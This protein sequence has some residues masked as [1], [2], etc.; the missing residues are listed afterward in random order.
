MAIEF[1]YK[2][3]LKDVKKKKRAIFGMY[4]HTS[5][6][7]YIYPNS[8]HLSHDQNQWKELSESRQ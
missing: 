2:I 6:G 5:N 4:L 1:I 3:R 7:L 8:A